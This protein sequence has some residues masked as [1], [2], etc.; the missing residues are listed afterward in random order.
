VRHNHEHAV[1]YLFLV[2]ESGGL[3]SD[4]STRW[5]RNL[6]ATR[7]TAVGNCV[8][9]KAE[10]THTASKSARKCALETCVVQG[11]SF[12]LENPCHMADYNFAAY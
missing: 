2:L 10:L 11:V 4:R 9:L 8:L 5:L 7:M 3:G 6:R 12:Y 1:F